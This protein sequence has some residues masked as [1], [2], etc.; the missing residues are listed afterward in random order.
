MHTLSI[1]CLLL[2]G[3]LYVAAEVNISHF[4]HWASQHGKM[5]TRREE[6]NRFAVFQSNMFLIQYLSSHEP[7]AVFGP[8]QFSDLTTREF[9]SLYAT[10][11][12]QTN[13]APLMKA[14]T[15]PTTR[16]TATS[17]NYTY[18]LPPIKNQGSCGSCWAFSAVGNMEAQTYM[19]NGG[20]VVSLSEQQFVECDKYDHGC[21]GGYMTNAE[22]YA[23]VNGVVATTSMPYTSGNGVVPK[24]PTKLPTIAARFRA[25]SWF[26]SGTSDASVTSLLATLGPLSAGI[27][28]G[29][30]YFQHYVNGI[31]TNAVSCGK[32]LNHGIVIV[33]Y[34]TASNVN[35]WL[36]RNSWGTSWG[37]H[38]YFRIVRGTDMCGVND[39]LS[40]IQA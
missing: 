20:H 6:R 30:A 32:T 7:L 12:V 21:G 35:Y 4:R 40:S 17:A 23:I 37:E 11:L 2:F 5:Y 38:G 14:S 33:G 24:C 16:S 18:M 10:G 13:A 36:L 22:Y 15:P 26:S 31:L 39:L 29:T 34:G 25:Y 3:T 27:A 19:H 9:S 8:N 1:I 28:A